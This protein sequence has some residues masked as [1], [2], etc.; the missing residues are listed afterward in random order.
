MLVAVTDEGAA[1]RSLA[2]VCDVTDMR[3]VVVSA[4]YDVTLFT[5]TARS[6]ISLVNHIITFVTKFGD[7]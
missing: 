6:A 5:S 2:A 4:H 1:S 3:H 7:I